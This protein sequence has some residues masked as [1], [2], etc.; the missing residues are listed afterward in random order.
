MYICVIRHG[1]TDWNVIGK[2]QGREDVPLNQNGVSQAERCALSL[3]KWKWKAIIT[4]PLLRASQTAEIIARTLNTQE[5][6]EDIDLIER[7]YG[8]ASGLTVEERVVRFPDS[9]YTGI[10][11]WTILRDRVYRSLLRSADRFSPD[12]IIVVSHG[13]AINSILAELSNHEIGTGK[14]RLKN[15][16]INVL[17]CKNRSFTVAFY[18]KTAD[19]IQEYVSSDKAKISLLRTKSNFKITDDFNGS[20]SLSG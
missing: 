8:E 20:A 6:Y 19:E 13:S 1:E 4:S 7:D 9:H 10:E 17:E 2:L 18:N 3:L 16:C 11:D 5:I 12:N 14:T 15:T